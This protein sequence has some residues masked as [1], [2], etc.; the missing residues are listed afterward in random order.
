M[1]IKVAVADRNSLYA[2]RLFNAL[3][4]QENLSLSVFNDREKFEDALTRTK[5]DIV[6]FDP[7][8]YSSMDVMRKVKMPIALYDEENSQWSIPSSV[9]TI[10]KYQRGS[11]IYSEMIGYFSEVVRDP[12]V[13]SGESTEK[14]RIIAFY[15]PIG[16]CGKTTCSIAA[17]RSIANKGRTVLYLSFEPFASYGAEFPL[18]G[19]KGIAELFSAMNGKISFSLKMESLVHKTSEG[20]MYFEKF[21]NVFDIYELTVSDVEDLLN[22]LRTK[23]G[24]DYIIIDM[25]TEYNEINRC[26]MENAA[27]I[28]IVDQTDKYSAAKMKI[29]AENPIVTREYGDKCCT[30]INRCVS[31]TGNTGFEVIGCIPEFKSG[32]AVSQISRQSFI[33]IER[34]TAD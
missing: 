27:K 25:G 14:G 21:E 31:G 28:V 22:E 3:R 17:A 2:E 24:V 26:I 1:K 12:S 15:S 6:L 9:R 11:T 10:R 23:S 34:M 30:I 33:D 16:G 5:F 7:S 29:F 4:M 8:V 32:D 20:V 13:L 19:G 18:K